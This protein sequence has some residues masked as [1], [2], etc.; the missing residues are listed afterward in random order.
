MLFSEFPEI[1]TGTDCIDIQGTRIKKEKAWIWILGKEALYS[2]PGFTNP[3][4]M[5]HI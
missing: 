4:E 2:W 3:S 1:N 5:G